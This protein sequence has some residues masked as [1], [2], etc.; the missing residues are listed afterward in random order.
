[1]QLFRSSLSDADLFGEPFPIQGAGEGNTAGLRVSGGEISPETVGNEYE[2]P[3]FSFYV[4]D[5]PRMIVPVVIRGERTSGV[6]APGASSWKAQRRRR[7][8][9]CVERRNSRGAFAPC[10]CACRRAAIRSKI[11]PSVS[12]F[13]IGIVCRGYCTGLWAASFRGFSRARAC[14][15]PGFHRSRV[16]HFGAGRR[17]LVV[18]LSHCN[19]SNG[20]VFFYDLD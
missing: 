9:R 15:I 5:T 11:W 10:A 1:M 14:K 18:F 13:A 2:S 17:D 16:S 8:L 7:R 3:A 20:S 19:E 12:E 6:P 4:W